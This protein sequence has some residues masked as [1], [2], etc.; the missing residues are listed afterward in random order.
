MVVE[1]ISSTTTQAAGSAKSTLQIGTVGAC[2]FRVWSTATKG[3]P[4]FDIA[5]EAPALPAHSSTNMAPTD[6]MSTGGAYTAWP[7]RISGARYH[8][9]TT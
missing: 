7:S 4:T 2:G 3:K 1:T 9:V 6:Q 5:F 8:R